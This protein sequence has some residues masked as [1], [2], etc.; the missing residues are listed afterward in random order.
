MCF[1]FHRKRIA[2]EL[3]KASGAKHFCAARE[4]VKARDTQLRRTQLAGAYNHRRIQAC[5]QIETN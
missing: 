4:S 3:R 2:E 5:Q 1:N